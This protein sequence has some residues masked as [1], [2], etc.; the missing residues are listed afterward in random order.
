[1]ISII[2]LWLFFRNVDLHEVWK[3]ISS[4]D[5]FLLSLSVVVGLSHNIFRCIRWRYLLS[6]IKRGIRFYNLFST[7]IIGYMVSW[8]IPGRIGELVRPVL[9]GQRE[10]VSKSAAVATIVIERIMDG[11]AVMFLFGV[12]L[13]FTAGRYSAQSS[14]LLKKATHAGITFS[15]LSILAFLFLLVLVWRKEGI[16][17]YIDTRWGQSNSRVLRGIFK[18]FHSFLEGASAVKDVRIL[19]ITIFYSLVVWFVIG[20]G[21]WLSLIATH[22]TIPLAGTFILLPLLVIG[23]A[24]PTPGGVGSYHEFMKIGL[25]GF[26]QVSREAAVS[27]AIVVHAITIIPVIILGFVFL[28]RD[29]L[30]FRSVSSINAVD[31][32]A[33]IQ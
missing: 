32:S 24:I 30:S 19:I 20:C 14:D 5:F 7:T 13:F 28:W 11:L 26:F 9:L 15:I 23:I 12:F 3:G 31:R 33:K 25:I 21:I 4:S 8:V 27:T 17:S 18:I 29:G 16:R 10:K 1:M 6:P 2:L 22:V